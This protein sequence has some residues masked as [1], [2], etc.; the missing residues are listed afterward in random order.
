[1]ENIEQRLIQKSIEAFTMAIEIYNKPT[2]CY[3]IEGFS[4]FICNSWEL[5]LKAHLINKQGEKSVYYKNNLERT[6]SLENC[7]ERIFTNNKDPL[8]INLEKIIELRN[9]STH[10]VTTDHELIYAPLFQSCVLNYSNKLYEM[11]NIDICSF[12]PH[13]FLTLSISL[14]PFDA[15]EVKAKY[16]PAIATKLLKTNDELYELKNSNPN[17]AFSIQ[18]THEHFITKN[19]DKADSAFSISSDASDSIKLVKILKDPNDTHKYKTSGCVTEINNRIRKDDL[20][21]ASL[22]IDPAKE[23]TF[24]I[25]HFGLFTS[26]YALKEDKKYCYKYNLA[27]N[28]YSYSYSMAIID[29]IYDEIKKD[30]EHII[31]NLKERIKK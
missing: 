20:P 23:K 21:F 8:R 10:F 13:N 28:L 17:P 9:T 12:I 1:M 22:S 3:R 31:H 7:I 14:S 24:N 11:F 15:N 4:F 26:Y 6:I 30:P 2:I 29:F 18:I 16:S 5:L 25:Y 19:P 27:N